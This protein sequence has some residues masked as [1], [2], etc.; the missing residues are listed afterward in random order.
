MGG[1]SPPHVLVF[2]ELVDPGVH[3]QA[4]GPREVLDRLMCVVSQRKCHG[5]CHPAT[6]PNRDVVMW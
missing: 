2:H 6:E 1:A 5:V 4:L 3:G